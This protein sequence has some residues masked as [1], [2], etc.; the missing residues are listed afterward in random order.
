MF[1]LACVIPMS[2]IDF[3]RAEPSRYRLDMVKPKLPFG[4][5][6]EPK[7]S[8]STAAPSE[9]AARPHGLRLRTWSFLAGLVFTCGLAADYCRA[10][11]QPTPAEAV[12]V[13]RYGID[14]LIALAIRNHPEIAAKRAE[15]AAAQSEIAAARMQYWP[16]PSIQ[17]LQDKGGTT[18]VLTVQ[19]PL[20]AGGGLDANLA[21]ARSRESAAGWSVAEAQNDLALRV[22]AAWSA[23]KQARGRADAL[24]EGVALLDVYTESVNRRIQGGVSAEVDRELVESRRAQFGGDLA[25]ARANE[26]AALLRLAQLTGQVLRA[27]DLVSAPDE[28]DDLPALDVLIE[29]AQER[30]PTLKR[31]EAEI[32]AAGHETDRKRAAR[33]PTLNLRAQHQR[34]EAQLG[35]N[36]NDS[37]LL[38]ALD[39]APGAGLSAGAN[40][41]AAE[42]RWQGLRASL[43]AARRALIDQVTTEY[44]EYRSS[45]NRKRDAERAIKASAEVLA[46]YDRLFVA[47]KRGWLDVINA[48]RELIQARMPLA[49]IEAARIASRTRL[50]LYAGDLPWQQAG[51][52]Q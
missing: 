13:S 52:T 38:L 3:V 25:Q 43:D 36:V 41:E 28:V 42:A 23:W 24:R 50:H 6:R 30:S 11:A 14:Q 48:A 47:G 35:V 9:V 17:A 5:C 16:T 45:L 44:E 4:L 20:W 22:T 27:E 39:Y 46:S 7:L 32:E 1:I 10:E 19:Q 8:A 29:Q 12:A 21:A 40:I 49:D 34:G 15:R 2:D 33:W 37:R 26:R 18:T 31:I 51:D